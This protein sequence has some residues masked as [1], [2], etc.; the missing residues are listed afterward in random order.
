M[1]VVLGGN[2]FVGSAI[3]QYLGQQEIPYRVVS[4][5]EVDYYDPDRLAACLKQSQAKFLVNCAGFTGKP[6]V[7]ACEYQKAECLLANAVLPDRIRQA[8]QR[9]SIPWCHVSSGCIYTGT[10][11]DGRGFTETDPPNFSFRTNNCSYYSGSKAMGEE[12]LADCD[13]CYI[14]RLRIPFN[15]VDAPRNYLSKLLRYQVLLEATN[16]LTHLDDFARATIQLYERRA[17]F[18]IYNVTNGG[19]IKTSE[20]TQML[21]R[22]LAPDQVFRF[23]AS[24]AMFMLVAKT[25]RSNCILDNTKLLST[26]IEMVPVAEAI[27]RALRHWVRANF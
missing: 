3:V 13:Q 22:S 17:P 24:E 15:H 27:E 14:V 18:G 23:F 20:I 5:S 6:N 16:S 19:H 11:P 9:A 26:G 1:I 25:P 21:Q 8:C 2:G 7:E 12:I 10:R 4:R